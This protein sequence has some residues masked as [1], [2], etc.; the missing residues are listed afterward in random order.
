[1]GT[2]AVE[3]GP[4]GDDTIFVSFAMERKNFRFDL[5]DFD[6]AIIG[7]TGRYKGAT[8]EVIHTGIDTTEEGKNLYVAEIAVPRFKRF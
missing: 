5:V 7:G 3:L 8:G 4:N 1:M 6:Q 2:F